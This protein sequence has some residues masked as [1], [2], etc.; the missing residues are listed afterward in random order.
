VKDA[1]FEAISTGCPQLESIKAQRCLGIGDKS[2]AAFGSSCPCLLTLDLTGCKN[3]TNRGIAALARGCPELKRVLLVGCGNL[4]DDSVCTLVHRCSVLESLSLMNCVLLSDNVPI[5]VSRSNCRWSL[6]N[7]NLRGLGDIT[8]LGVLAL[9][10]CSN[11]TALD[12]TF[13]LEV[14][15]V[16][17]LE[18]AGHMP[19][20]KKSAGGRRGL[21]PL[22]RGV[23]LFNEVLFD[24]QRMAD[25]VMIFQTKC[26]QHRAKMH[27]SAFRY[28]RVTA[29]VT[30]QR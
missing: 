25:A 26:R 22:A 16:A 3:I 13:C 20:A 19:F 12:V 7:L 2:L 17:L 6:T 11:L 29:I 9:K 30:I 14:S 8:D 10:G 5:E 4:T 24:R 27:Y 18:T 28:E 21:E 15:D 1:A 23:R